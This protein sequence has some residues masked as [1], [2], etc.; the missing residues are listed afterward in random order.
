MIKKLCRSTFALFIHEMRLENQ[1]KELKITQT[2]ILKL[3]WS[4]DG[5]A[6]QT[7][8]DI[9]NKIGLFVGCNTSQGY[10]IFGVVHFPKKSL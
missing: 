9:S 8:I 1:E 2:N 10:R 3:M 4:S 6:I 5:I 7:G